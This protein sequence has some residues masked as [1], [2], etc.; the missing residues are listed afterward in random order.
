MA[1]KKSHADRIFYDLPSKDQD[2]E[3]T[4]EKDPQALLKL[5]SESEIG[6]NEKFLS[7]FGHRQVVYCDY[8]ASGRSLSF[9]EDFIRSQVLPDYGNTHTTSTVTSLQT[10]LFRQEARDIVRN[11]VN[12]SEHDLVVFVSSGTTGAVNKLLNALELSEPPVVFVS[13]YE[14][15][16]NLLPWREALAEVVFINETQ[17]GSV[18]LDDLQSK[19]EQYQHD[20]RVRIGSFSAASNITGILSDSEKIT[21]LLHKYGF[22]SF[23]D[24]ASAA[25]HVDVNMNPFVS[26]EEDKELAHKDAIFLSVHKFVG[27]P[28]TPGILIAKKKLFVN[29]VP[30]GCGGGTVFYVTKNDHRYLKNDEMRE[31]G[32]TPAIV[33]SIRAGLVFQLKNAI[34]IDTILNKEDHYTNG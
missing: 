12:A 18:D 31:E 11:C 33:E 24:F 27:G 21:I 29:R 10:T 23:W 30:D 2:E 17:C 25:P 7:P 8:T 13:P 20:R 26:D 1:N 3:P 22:L 28:Q 34:G 9:I 32:G 6:A 16:S 19:L 4:G 15:H 14:H 5:I